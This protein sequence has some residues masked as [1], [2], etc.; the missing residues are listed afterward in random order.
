MAGPRGML[1]S[2]YWNFKILP[3]QQAV[4]MPIILSAKCSLKC[5]KRGSIIFSSKSLRP[6]VLILGTE[7]YG[8][9]PKGNTNIRIM[10]ELVI[11]GKGV[12]W[13]GS[14]GY[15]TIREGARLE[16]GNNFQI[17]NSWCIYSSS[18]SKIGNNCMFSW[19][20]LL[21]DTD[22]HPIY[23][24]DD[25]LLNEPMPFLISDNVWLGAYSKVLKGST[26]PN[27]SIIATGSTITKKLAHS[28]SIYIGNTDI[29]HN[30]HWKRA[31]L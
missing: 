8:F 3:I 20:I 27:G 26:I 7:Y 13:F 9:P 16:I 31:P 14:N 1:K 11:H 18:N 30:V 2:L 29:K 6:G 28:D 19:N 10:G 4:R 17:G 23:G 12:H 5:C 22:S 15:M 24:A 21:L 25:H